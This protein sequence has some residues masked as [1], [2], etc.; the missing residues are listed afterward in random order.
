VSGRIAK[1]WRGLELQNRKVE[2]QRVAADQNVGHGGASLLLVDFPWPLP[3]LPYPTLSIPR[4]RNLHLGA[5]GHASTDPAHPTIAQATA[6]CC[7]MGMF[8]VDQLLFTAQLIGEEQGFTLL[9]PRIILNKRPHTHVGQA[10]L[11][12]SEYLLLFVK[13]GA[14][15]LPPLP[16]SVLRY[17]RAGLMHSEKPVGIRDMLERMFPYLDNRLELFARQRVPG[18]KGW[19][20][21]YPAE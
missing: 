15:P 5:D 9:F 13:G 12:A 1:A 7:A 17:S 6:P 20:N 2:R 21:E 4:I 19:G 16:N 10:A 14:M 18:W 8:A 11:C 3:G